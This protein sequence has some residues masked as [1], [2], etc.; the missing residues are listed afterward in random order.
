[1]NVWTERRRA[2][3]EADA[4]LGGRGAA[5][6]LLEVEPFVDE[7]RTR[8]AEQPAPAPNAALE[9]V[10]A[11]GLCDEEPRR[12]P[13]VAW[14]PLRTRDRAP[15]WTGSRRVLVAV[16]AATLV[17]GG[18][19]VAGAVPAVQNAIADVAERFGID[20]PRSAP[21]P[22]HP[23]VP[24]TGGSGGASDAVNPA[25]PGVAPAR[26]GGTPGSP[27]ASSPT[28]TS[29]STAPPGGGGGGA[30]IDVPPITAPPITVPSITVP[31]I[32]LPP[33]TVPSG[34]PIDVPPIDL[35]P[36]TVPPI[37]VPPIDLPP[38]L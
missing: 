9:Q 38:I 21:A 4:L 7:L 26:S 35:P 3:A 24:R 22:Q 14:L 34:L 8:Y 27:S 2:D 13:A 32:D 36:I 30:G 23:A 10:L 25:A 33:V 12:T 17:L 15:M 20:L 37:T 28:G 1:M 5:T 29:P 6:A 19:A 16:L 31:P 11:W 18:L